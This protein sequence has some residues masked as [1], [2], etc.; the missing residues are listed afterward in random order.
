M[1]RAKHRPPSPIV[2][3]PAVGDLRFARNNWGGGYVGARSAPTYP[4]PEGGTDPAG[5]A[6]LPQLWL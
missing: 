2:W 4:P 3:R 5:P 6:P 1:F